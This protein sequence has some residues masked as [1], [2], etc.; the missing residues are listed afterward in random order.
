MWW[1][2]SYKTELKEYLRKKG[3][4]RYGMKI[5]SCN[6]KKSGLNRDF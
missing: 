6:I 5:I 3:T 2:K 1:K 4:G